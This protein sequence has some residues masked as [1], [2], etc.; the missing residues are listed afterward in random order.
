MVSWADRSANSR[1]MQFNYGNAQRMGCGYY[2][3]NDLGWASAIAP[4]A[5]VWHYLVLTYAGG[6][7]GTEKVYVDGVLNNTAIKTLNLFAGEPMFLGCAFQQ[8]SATGWTFSGS[9][10]GVRI[11]DGV[12]TLAQV[13]DL[14]IHNGITTYT[15]SGTVTNA[16]GTALSGA[17]VYFS[18]TGG[19][20]VS[21]RDSDNGRQRQLQPVAA[22]RDV[23]HGGGR[24]RLCYV[25]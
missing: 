17:T 18:D 9:L 1:D 6:S 3:S 11:T 14:Y 13:Q 20:I 7:N 25:D 22:Q 15:V 23:V 4:T 10:A 21:R 16:V 12:L 5:G 19:G 2:M 8:R 24:Q